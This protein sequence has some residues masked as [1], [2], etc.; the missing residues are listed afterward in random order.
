MADADQLIEG[1]GGH[2][3]LIRSISIIT[4]LYERGILTEL[5][6]SGRITEEEVE[7]RSRLIQQ[8]FPDFAKLQNEPQDTDTG[9]RKPEEK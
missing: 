5:I 7:T 1:E 2:G 3:Y 9:N 4:L 8:R 6:E